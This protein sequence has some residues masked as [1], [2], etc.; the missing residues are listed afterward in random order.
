M[1]NKTPLAAKM[2]P[3]RLEEIQGQSHILG[4]NKLLSRLIKADMLESII[5]YGPPGTGKTTLAHVIACTTSA[6]FQQLNATTAGKK[7]IE[8][9]V[10][11]AKAQN[12][13][14]I[15]FIDE[16]HR[17]NK[18]QQDALLPEVESGTI[19][20]IGATTENPY[21]EVNKALL[22][23]S[24]IFEL[25]PLSETEICQL[26]QRTLADTEKGLGNQCIQMD[27]EATMLIAALSGGD[28][29]FALNTLEL[30]AI[31]T[32]PDGNGCTHITTDTIE[33]CTQR[34]MITYDKDGD[35]HYDIIS[36]FIKSMRGSDPDA[37][38]YYLAVLLEAGEDIKFIARRIVIHAAEDVGLADP[39][40]LVVASAAATAVQFVGMPEARIILTEAV[41]YIATAP[42]SNGCITAIETA[43]HLAKTKPLQVPSHLQD[44]HYKSA[45][46]LGRGV[47][48]KYPHDYP[49]H[50]VD[51]QYLPDTLRNERIYTPGTFGR[52]REYQVW[53]NHWDQVFQQSRQQ[54]APVQQPTATSPMLPPFSH[55][56]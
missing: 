28:A 49:G 51:Q 33:N 31:S 54:T 8:A 23:R 14:T 37:A 18:L 56:Q 16:I 46:N 26:I 2:R 40:A 34:R 4:E 22:S 1:Q 5:L 48:Y 45:K 20:L 11:K 50:M 39:Q 44:A 47:G 7:D 19:V 36:A 10:K 53:K 29:R 35:N 21:F 25:K 32:T 27:P 12:L 17:F 13:P 55:Q 3:T 15:L 6:N 24:R 41:L 42:K 30:A 52:E 9:I 38:V 43:T